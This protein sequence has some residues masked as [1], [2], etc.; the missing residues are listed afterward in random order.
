MVPAPPSSLLQKRDPDSA[1]LR[2]TMWFQDAPVSRQC[3]ALSFK[4]SWLLVLLSLG[5]G[6]QGGLA[7]N[8]PK[9]CVCASNIISCSKADLKVFPHHLPHYSVVLDFSHNQLTHLRA[10]WTPFELSHLHSLFLSHNGLYF[11]STEA[12]SNV[13]HLKYLDLSSNAID[14]LGENIFSK[15]IELEVLLL[16]SNKITKIDR[17][18]FDDMANLQKLYLSH[19]EISRFPLELVKNGEAKLPELALLDLSSNKIKN[20][21]VDE[22]KEIPAWMKNGL[23]VH[24][25]PLSCQCDL[26]NLFTH[27]QKR[28]LS[29]AVD[30]EEELQ[31]LDQ[32]KNK[33]ITISSLYDPEGMNCSTFKEEVL[34][35]HRG[36]KATINCDTRQRGV[37]VKEWVTP[38]YEHVQQEDHNDTITLLP[39]G[40]LLIS[41]IS[42]DD[43]GLYT[44]YAVSQVFNET[45]YVQVIVHNYTLHGAPD[46]FNTAYTTLVG[47]ILSVILVLIYLYLTPCRCWCRS[48]EKQAN[49]QEDSINS[50]VL[51]TTPNHN[52]EVTGDKEGLNRNTVPSRAQ[53]QNGKCKPTNSPKHAPKGVQKVERKLSDPE[54]VSSVFSDTPIVGPSPN[55]G[56]RGSSRDKAGTELVGLL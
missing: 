44:C 9:S 27:W 42:T 3:L 34:E 16:F 24:S 56:G 55:E 52:A 4:A 43:M 49:Q 8:C 47:C 5:T 33:N 54:S 12:F 20:L 32:T 6:R 19:N 13:P 25:N 35:F 41:N 7:L 28:Q 40:S 39:N 36:D 10:E 11:I 23:Y 31:C 17:T 29:S 1:S 30:F 21:H 53:G 22:V 46:M 51:S 26:Y 37:T 2:L 38:R 45:L 50:S 18:A 14:T 48:N 15:L